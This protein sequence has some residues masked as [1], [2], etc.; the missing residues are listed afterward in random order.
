M[1]G[2]AFAMS[3]GSGGDKY[4]IRRYPHDRRN[5]ARILCK[6]SQADLKS[7]YVIESP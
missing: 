1:L 4:P 7:L 3:R 2:R 6:V 5:A